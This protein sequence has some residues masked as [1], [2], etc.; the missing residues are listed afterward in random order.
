[1]I[2]RLLLKSMLLPPLCQI[3]LAGAGLWLLRRHPAT[4]KALIATSLTSLFALATPLASNALHARLENTPALSPETLPSIDAQ[5][6]V[7]LTGA[8]NNDTPEFGHPI[9]S[10]EALMRLRYAAFLQRRTQLPLL[11]TG[12]F[13]AGETT[14]SLA[15]TA[16]FDL[17]DGF[18]V[19]PE[20]LESSSRTTDENA[21]FSYDMLAAINIDK[22]LLVSSAYHMP[23]A[24][25]LFEAAG[26]EVVPAPTYFV[27]QQPFRFHQLIPSA[28]ALSDSTQAL[29]EWLGLLYYRVKTT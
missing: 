19:T 10:G 21:K 17:Q 22:I 26:F 8:Q 23:R 7:V 4:G 15:H 14:T 20:W 11:V 2:I 28:R 12:G 27:S 1:M 3:I 25:L 9:S 16:A 5:A 18:Q 6:I 24:Q 13:T 29:H